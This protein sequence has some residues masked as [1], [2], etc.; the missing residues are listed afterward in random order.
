MLQQVVQDERW[1]GVDNVL[2]RYDEVPGPHGEPPALKGYSGFELRI[3]AQLAGMIA[4]ET[5]W[6]PRVLSQ[7]KETKDEV[8]I[9]G[10]GAERTI[11]V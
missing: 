10:A 7:H 2:T 1:G 11:A 4:T 8:L 5:G 3:V 6:F 9:E